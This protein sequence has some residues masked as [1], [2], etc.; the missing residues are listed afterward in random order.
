MDFLVRCADFYG[1]SCD[2]LLGRS[3]VPDGRQTLSLEDLPESDTRGDGAS[4]LGIVS[5]LSKKLI[6]NSLNIVF[7]LLSKTKN[8]T[9]I[10]EASG[11]LMLSVYRVFRRLHS[12][13]PKNQKELFK[14]PA[15]MEENIT[16]SLIHISP[17][18]FSG[19]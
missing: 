11:Y 6:F 9:L 12:A 8:K 1:V 17:P 7:D 14:I 19:G 4:G 18:A 15:P 3:P 13:N 10:N 16:L 5:A 2:Y